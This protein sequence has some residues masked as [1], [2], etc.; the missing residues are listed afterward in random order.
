MEFE[1]FRLVESFAGVCREILL[2]PKDFFHNL[3]RDGTIGNSFVFLAICV[4]LSCLVMANMLNGDY[5]LFLLLFTANLLSDFIMTGILHVVVKKAFSGQA[6]IAAT[7]RVFAYSSLTDLAAWI[8]L[9]GTIA[10]FYGLYL[11]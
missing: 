2:R 5:R 1:P 7:F 8:P 4:F 6:S 9:V 11:V 3:P 10:T